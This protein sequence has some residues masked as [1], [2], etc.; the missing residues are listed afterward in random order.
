M[1]KLFN[2]YSIQTKRKSINQQFIFTPFRI[3][4]TQINCFKSSNSQLG[5]CVK[6]LCNYCKYC[7]LNNCEIFVFDYI[8]E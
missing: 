3:E 1:E 8:N 5:G 4:Y 2:F 7:K 6:K